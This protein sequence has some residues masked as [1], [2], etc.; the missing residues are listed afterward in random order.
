MNTIYIADPSLISFEGHHYAL[1]KVFS[2]ALLP[3]SHTIVW[4]ANIKCD[5]GSESGY[6]VKKIFSDDVYSTFKR[7]IFTEKNTI[8][9]R[10]KRKIKKTIIYIKN[11]PNFI[12]KISRKSYQIL[13][14]CFI[15]EKLRTRFTSQH[16]AFPDRVQNRVQ[17]QSMLFA[18]ELSAAVKRLNMTSS[19]AIFFHSS[20][21]STYA[22]II[23]FFNFFPVAQWGALPSIHLS[24]PYDEKIMIGNAQTSL[25]SR[26]IQRLH[27]WNL[28]NSKIFLYAENDLLA[29]ELSKNWGTRVQPLFIPVA[30]AQPAPPSAPTVTVAYLG[31]AR[32]EKGFVFIADAISQFLK[33]NKRTDCRFIIQA[34]AQ[35]VGLHPDIAEA[36]NLLDAV[37]D[38]RLQIVTTPLDETQYEELVQTADI[39]LLCYDPAR[40]RI[41]SSGIVLEAAL[42]G[43]VC[44]CSQGSFMAH[45]ADIPG[46]AVEYGSVESFI[47]RLEFALD[48][49][50]QLSGKAGILAKQLEQRVDIRWFADFISEI[51][52]RTYDLNVAPCSVECSEFDFKHHR[53]IGVQHEEGLDSRR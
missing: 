48:N 49:F 21:A 12:G 35:I 40:Y 29:A 28:L 32:H 3:H 18:S 4:L 7:E 20:V 2:D 8:Q 52:N 6:S 30:R 16:T 26:S 47:E 24:T 44:L 43:K 51:Q 17:T 41:R 42:R 36:R 19:D 38:P 10:I 39:V 9:K 15:K 33:S 31:A 14:E 23:H 34:S 1:S 13:P 53:L 11:N 45:F 25:A 5:I 50:S 37:Q 27:A 46:T 22:A